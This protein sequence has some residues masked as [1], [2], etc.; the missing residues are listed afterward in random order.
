MVD[1]AQ[2]NNI[3]EARII[4]GESHTMLQENLILSVKQERPGTFPKGPD[5]VKIYP[6]LAISGGG[7]NGAYGAGLLK[8]WTKSGTRP[9]F[10][11][12][13]GVSTGALIAAFAFL[14]PDYD[15][16]LEKFY[17]TMSTKDVMTPKG[18]LSIL[19]GDSLASNKPLSRIIASI[20][21]KEFLAKV[22]A[23]HE[24]GY[25]LFVGTANL[26]AQ[27]FVVW[28]MGAIARRGDTKLFGDVILASAAIPVIFPPSIFKVE[29]D[30]KQYDE[31]HSDGGTITQVFTTYK[32]LEGMKGVA[33]D[34]DIETSDVRAKLYIIRNGYMS[35]EYKKVDDTLA[36][37]AERSFDTI[38]NSQ[39]VGDIYRLYL[40]MK[41]RNNDFN[42]A[43]IPSDFKQNCKEMFDPV[44]MKRLFDKGYNDAVN[45]YKWHKIPPGFDPSHVKE[46]VK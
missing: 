21:T 28:D 18:P 23:R 14:G 41:S 12:I 20:A 34:Q 40:F 46:D 25:R 17:T 2:I 6:V 30:G 29:A 36:A 38:I 16:E 24:Q 42:F 13:T 35:P 33:G 37:L 39:G 32:I 8:G 15:A 5:G 26:D 31:M 3:P 45:G 27:R 44:E 11:I 9:E 10:K 4:L 7:A 22:A 43:C 1:K 19:F